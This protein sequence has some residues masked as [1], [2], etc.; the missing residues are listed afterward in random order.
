MP[1]II[2][3][4]TNLINKTILK[5]K[6]KTNNKFKIS[7]FNKFLISFIGILFLYIFYL[8]T[9][10]LYDKDLVKN[11]IESKLLSEFKI[12][13]D[14]F[15]DISYRILPA[16]HFLIKDSKLLLSSSN[17]KESEA[18]VKNLKIFLSQKNLFNKN[19]IIIENVAINK[20]NFTLLRSDLKML[21]YS[22]NNQFSNNKIEI[23]KSNIFFKD[24]LDEVIVIIKIDQAT[25]FNEK[26]IL[27]N[28]LNLKGN[29]FT[30]PFTLEL[31]NKNGLIK[32]DEINFKAKSLDLNIFN[33][34][35]KK[36]NNLITG[37][38]IISFL[39]STIDTEYEVGDKTITFKST[40]SSRI[41]ISKVNYKGKLSINPFDLDLNINFNNYKISNIFNL[42]PILVE[43]LKS[44]LLFNDNISL[45]TSIIINSNS[46]DEIFNNAKIYFNIL[47]GK[48]N[49][50][51]SIFVNDN[52]GLLELSNSNL[53]FENNN[54]ILNTDLLF[55][56]KNS[57]G[58]FSF[59]NTKKD[60]RKNIKN[61]LVNLNYNFLS[62]EIEFN[63]LKINDKKVSSEFLNIINGFKD[64]NSNNTIKSR[65]LVNELLNIYE[66]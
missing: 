18:D 11:S 6:N 50:N 54:L 48:I 9:P 33:E 26:K 51:K 10:L 66:G 20:A 17:N 62:D 63:D 55:D 46:K 7:A 12:Q 40:N 2:K 57:N 44:E 24:N 14:S 21:D 37:R 13:L 28:M 1:Q 56:I 47:N 16:P 31:K 22:S 36:K 49:L 38:N 65:R 27:S 39:N 43:F 32:R 45:N 35:I 53:F 23:T 8:L 41:N 3:N 34:S 30:I 29:I 5:V 61:I 19:K 25:L 15:N 58:L 42:N 60:S 59:L 4:F 52:I 64:N